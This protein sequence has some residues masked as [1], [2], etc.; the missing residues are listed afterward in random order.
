M[1]RWLRWKTLWMVVVNQEIDRSLGLI[2]ACRNE[3]GLCN[4]GSL[5]QHIAI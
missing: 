1:V 2:I 4:H 3:M 5:T